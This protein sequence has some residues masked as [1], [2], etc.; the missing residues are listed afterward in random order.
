MANLSPEQQTS[1]S[2]PIAAESMSSL[3]PIDTLMAAN[4]AEQVGNLEEAKALYEAVLQ[5]DPTGAYAS[6]AQQALASLVP[7][8]QTVAAPQVI[9]DSIP[10][11]TIGQAPRKRKGWWQ[12]L[13]LRNKQSFILT[14]AA[15][16]PVLVL[17]GVNFF[18]LQEELSNEFLER[19]Q[20][21]ETA[22][23]EEY[24][25]GLS[26]SSLPQAEALAQLIESEPVNLSDPIAVN[27][28]RVKL[29]VI[30]RKAFGAFDRL[31]PTLTKSFRLVADVNG[32]TLIQFLQLYKEAPEAPLRKADAPINN[33]YQPVSQPP[34]TQLA[35]IPIV[36]QTLTTGTPF[37]SVERIPTSILERL[38]LF[39]QAQISVREQ[40]GE[41]FADALVSLATHPVKY[42]GQ[43]VG[44]VVVG[45]LLNR[46]HAIIDTFTETF[47]VPIASIYAQD[48]MVATSAP[49]TDQETRA[50]GVR[51]PE[52]VSQAIL[53]EKQPQFINQETFGGLS[54]LMIYSPIL[55]SQGDAIGM[56]AVGESQA[57]LRQQ[58]IRQF[59]LNA[60]LGAVILVAA[61]AAARPVA[62]IFSRRA[63]ELALFAQRVA[64]GQLGVRVEVGE[65]ED[66]LGILALEMNK[67]AEGI[68]QNLEAA[69]YQEEL[70]R[71]EAEQQRLEK[72][73]L[74]QGVIS[75]LLEIEGAQRGNLTVRA[76]ITEG[77]VGSIADAFNATINNLQQLVLQ[78]RGVATQVEQLA[79]SSEASVQR[80]SGS[81][82]DQ[83]HEV[84]EALKSVDEISHSIQMT[85]QS[86][87]EAAAIAQKVAVE[88]QTG[89]H[90]IEETV[91]RMDKI[92]SA[93][94]ATA[95]K[96]ERLTR[97]SQEIA[98]VT[99]L[100]SGIS[101][102]TNLLAF[103]ASVEAMRAGENGA[104]FRV[105]A[106]EV[107]RL[108]LRVTD[109][110]KTIEQL[111]GNIQQETVE[112]YQAMLE[113][114]TEVNAGT[115]LVGS[116]KATLRG[117]SQVSQEIN[118]YLQTIST[119]T[120]AQRE[121]S[122]QVNQTMEHVVKTAEVT[123][124]AAEGVVETLKRLSA[125]VDALQQS[126]SR[127]QLEQV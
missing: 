24:I 118:A 59:S 45:S 103:N 120:S 121:S 36:K 100:I 48:V 21:L 68:E 125:E 15:A 16:V 5:M 90:L 65:E 105:V 4:A 109:A 69:R 78:V 92:R 114:T 27:S 37:T 22:F 97:S 112:V 108:A 47:E 117:L 116:V 28:N 2:Q 14:I 60:I 50:I 11:T 95:Q 54:Y 86:T 104:G 57:T 94:A 89:D 110:T 19:L 73:R 10:S 70:R 99:T 106:D 119:S 13:N 18:V 32:T 71:Q 107:R 83:S 64:S 31:D 7:L 1:G 49:F 29:Q 20:R 8:D 87:R 43:I 63:R 30:L 81:A 126:M 39:Q 79:K 98:K 9:P 46:N 44:V 56:I 127:F 72:E 115:E 101:E 17:A 3:S 52:I 85:A 33:T 58:I 96:V 26:Q 34:G 55:N 76:P 80:L 66:E 51:A 91:A 102:K 82:I 93:V 42:R 111:V 53:K 40:E 122:Q 35:D 75:L 88:A 23:R 38:A 67:M 25:L 124:K 84:T 12:S 113:G 61:F 41:V 123:T 77:A 6:I 62:E 74:Q